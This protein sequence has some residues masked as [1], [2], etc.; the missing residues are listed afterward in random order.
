MISGIKKEKCLI[1]YY[2]INRKAYVIIEKQLLSVVVEYRGY[3][4]KERSKCNY[5]K[6]T[7]DCLISTKVDRNFVKLRILYYLVGTSYY[8]VQKGQ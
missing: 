2:M 5:E 7:V 8:R 6:Y 4:I 1:Q 3:K